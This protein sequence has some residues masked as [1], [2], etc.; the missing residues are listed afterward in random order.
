MSREG[1]YRIP[2]LLKTANGDLIAAIDERNNSCTD[3]RGNHD[4]NIVLKRSEDNGKNWT[5]IQRIIDEPPGISVSDPSMILDKSNGKVF[6]FYNYMD[7]VHHPNVYFLYVIT[8]ADHGKSWS[9]PIDITKQI[10]Q[11]EWANDFKFITSGKG[12]QTSDGTLLHTLVNL[13]KGMHL[14]G[15]RDHGV[16]W[17][18]IDTPIQPADESK[19][20]EL[21]DGRW[22]INSRVNHSGVR[23][24]HTSSDFGQT[25]ESHPDSTLLDPSCNASMI[26]Y[27]A[28]N[29]NQK[30]N[31]IVFVNAYSAS[32]RENLTIQMSF[33]EGKTWPIR[34]TIYEGPAAYASAVILDNGDIGVFFEKDDYADNTFVR[35][36]LEWVGG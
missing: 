26:R 20:I 9:E 12:I 25:W 24:V 17:F 33:D 15:S 10:S 7:L 4:I 34:K 1:C 32:K 6:L 3:L 16:S 8:S 2:S 21:T 35:L 11:K 31:R 19:I 14:F 13:D 29:S 22:M 5:G 28:I 23:F 18:L 27:T 30:K 36:N